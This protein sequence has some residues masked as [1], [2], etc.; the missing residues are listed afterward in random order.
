MTKKLLA[1]PLALTLVLLACSVPVFA[2][3][4]R[5][6]EPAN[7]PEAKAASEK[8]TSKPN[9]KLK[10]D[11]EKLLAAAKA[12]KVAPQQQQFPS[13]SR[14]NLSKTAKIAIIASAIGATIF[15]AILFHDLS[16]D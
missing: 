4:A 3:G 2:D 9:T 16:K 12:G 14:N 10:K 1:G 13:T 7:S 5:T 8:A 15:L 6:S 11:M